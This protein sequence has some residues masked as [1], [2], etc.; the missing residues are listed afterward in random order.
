MVRLRRTLRVLRDGLAMTVH[1]ERDPV[2]SANCPL[3]ALGAPPGYRASP[4]GGPALAWRAPER[5]PCARGPS[6]VTA[7]G[8]HLAWRVSRSTGSLWSQLRRSV[9]SPELGAFRQAK[10]GGGL[11]GPGRPADTGWYR[12]GPIESDASG[13][14]LHLRG[15]AEVTPP[16]LPPRCRPVRRLSKSAETAACIA[17]PSRDPHNSSGLGGHHIFMGASG[18]SER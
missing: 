7:L 16:P 15:H 5:F 12:A 11:N 13:P 8:E 4:G 18:P 9:R 3:G 2:G 1:S 6:Q 10:G 14:L 17:G